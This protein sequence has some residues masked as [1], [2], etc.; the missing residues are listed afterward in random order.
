MPIYVAHD[1]VD[2]WQYRHLFQLDATGIPAQVAGVPPDAYSSSGQKWRHPLYDWPAHRAEDFRWWINRIRRN[3]RLCDLLRIDH[4]IGFSRYYAIP[5]E[6]PDGRRGQW[7]EGP[8]AAFF[9][10]LQK[11]IGA[12]PLW[13]EDL[14]DLD[15]ATEALR[16][17]L[18]LPGML[19]LQFALEPPID[20][21]H[22]FE[23]HRRNAVVYPSTHDTDTARGW[24]Q[25]LTIEERRRALPSGDGGDVARALVHRALSSSAEVAILAAQDLLGLSSEARMNT[26]GIKEGNWRWRL[27]DGQLS[28]A[29]GRELRAALAKTDR[30]RESE[31]HSG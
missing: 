5:T 3:L 20:N 2:V 1:S 15:T 9:A 22:A 31:V 26:P 19:V 13:A 25:G 8:G 10:A 4:F 7:H 27:C 30:I 12:L 21:P 16:D 28:T 23:N 29:L 17:A 14:G 6:A 18:G 24:W 11:A